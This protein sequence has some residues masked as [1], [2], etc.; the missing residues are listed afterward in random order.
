MEWKRRAKSC[1][2]IQKAKKPR[3]RERRRTIEKWKVFIAQNRRRSLARGRSL[4]QRLPE[5][6]KAFEQG[7]QA[8]K[9]TRQGQKA[10]N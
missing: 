9:Y 7:Q 6:Q 1:R 2:T 8:D 3:F 4:F 10:I 5:R